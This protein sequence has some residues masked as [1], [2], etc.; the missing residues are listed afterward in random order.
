MT[1]TA[2]KI[3]DLLSLFLQTLGKITYQKHSLKKG[4]RS[5]PIIT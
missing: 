3:W 1:I 4:D 2:S 5:K